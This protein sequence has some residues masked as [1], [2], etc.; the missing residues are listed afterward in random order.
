MSIGGVDPDTLS[1]ALSRE[2]SADRR[3][4]ASGASPS[5]KRQRING[6][7]LVT[8]RIPCSFQRL[9]YLI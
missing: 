6:D 3:D 7:R 9:G 4:S 5:R 2:L 1:R 8:A